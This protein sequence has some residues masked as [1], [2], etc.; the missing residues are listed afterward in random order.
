VT[1]VSALNGD[2]KLHLSTAKEE[3]HRNPNK[4]IHRLE[5][6]G[7][8]GSEIKPKPQLDMPEVQYL[9]NSPSEQLAE[10]VSGKNSDWNPVTVPSELR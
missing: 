2:T 6:A 9:F 1:A 3:S 4:A 5:F 10:Q 8:T 7:R